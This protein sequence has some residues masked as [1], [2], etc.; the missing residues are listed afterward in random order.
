[1]PGWLARRWRATASIRRLV[2]VDHLYAQTSVHNADSG[3]TRDHSVSVEIRGS[4]GVGNAGWQ[5]RSRCLCRASGGPASDPR[6][7]EMN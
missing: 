4:G 7:I 1:M 5:G 3:I 2:P 6:L